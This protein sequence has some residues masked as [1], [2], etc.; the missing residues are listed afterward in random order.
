[1]RPIRHCCND[2]ILYRKEYENLKEYPSYAESCYKAKDNGVG[3]DDGVT[4]KGV[5]SKVMLYLPII[6]RF[7]KMFANANHTNNTIWHTNERLCDGKICHVADSLQ[8]KKIDYVFLD[9]SL[10]PRNIRLGLSTKRM[11]P[12]GN[13]S[14]NHTSWHVLLINYNLSPWLCMKH[15]Y[16]VNNDDFESKTTNERHRCLFNAID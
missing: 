11:N 3:D 14:T 5:P 13:L 16:D 8:W 12:F 4:R 6:Q 2:C 1:M 15:T 7:K 10:E 9:F